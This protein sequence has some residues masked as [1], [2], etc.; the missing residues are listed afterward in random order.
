M[1][2]DLAAIFQA[3]N[4]NAD[5]DDPASL[6][7]AKLFRTACRR[8]IGLV[9]EQSGLGTE[10]VRYGLTTKAV[11]AALRRVQSWINVNDGTGGSSYLD[12][13]YGRA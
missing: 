6:A 1:A 8:I 3:Y 13:S 11:E 9:P 4:D 7:K 10:L 2:I 5:Y 12:L